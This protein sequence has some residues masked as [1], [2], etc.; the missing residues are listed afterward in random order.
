MVML[1]YTLLKPL[2]DRAASNSSYG[3]SLKDYGTTKYVT[4]LS[5]FDLYRLRREFK[6]YSK[7]KKN[8]YED[9]CEAVVRKVAAHSKFTLTEYQLQSAKSE[10]MVSARKLLTEANAYAR[11]SRKNYILGGIGGLIVGGVMLL[12]GK[13]QI[14]APAV[15]TAFF[16][17]AG[18]AVGF[19]MGKNTP[20]NDAPDMLKDKM[21]EV[22]DN[23]YSIVQRKK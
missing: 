11:A 4:G 18:A 5:H 22:A 7:G 14:K 17:V 6:L 16:T 3:G 13:F 12:L 1:P 15:L 10:I 2:I 8:K 20:Y 23:A 9:R 21:I 19:A